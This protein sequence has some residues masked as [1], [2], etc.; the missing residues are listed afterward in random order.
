MP[1]RFSANTRNVRAKGEAYQPARL[2]GH[3]C[4]TILRSGNYRKS[5]RRFFVFD[6]AAIDV[7]HHH[8]CKSGKDA[9]EAIKALRPDIPALFISGYT[10]DILDRKG[11]SGEEVECISKPVHPFD[12]L[13]KVREVLDRGN[14]RA[15]PRPCRMLHGHGEEDVAGQQQLAHIDLVAL[16]FHA[17]WSFPLLS[18]R[19]ER[20]SPRGRR[21]FPHCRQ[22]PSCGTRS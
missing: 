2:E 22:I 13:R 18:S 21:R 3:A 7:R 9:F 17:M 1:S 6:F 14:G 16:Q 12:L 10:A 15:G 11:I 19:A 8:A 5:T 20:L 4:I